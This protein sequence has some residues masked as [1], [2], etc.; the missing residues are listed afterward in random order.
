MKKINYT[1]KGLNVHLISVLAILVAIASP[2]FDTSVSNHSFVKT[3]V[4][5]IG[6]GILLL[7]TF[8]IRPN[9]THTDFHISWLKSSLL[10]LFILGTLSVF[11]SVNVD[12]TITKWLIWFTILCAFIVGYHLKLDN[13]VLIKFCWGLLIATFVITGI[14]LLQYWFDPFSL[15]QAAVPSSTFGNKNMATQPVVMMWPLALF[16]LFSKHIK[17]QQVWIVLTLTSLAMVFIVFTG[18]RSS[19]LAV[20]GQIIII[21]G[22]LLIK[23]K[24][25]STWI[26]WDKN[27]TY[28]SLFALLLLLLLTNLNNITV[29]TETAADTLASIGK[30]AIQYGGGRNVRLNIWPIA[31]DMIKANPV[32]GSGLGT[33]FHNEVQGGFGTYNVINYQRVHNDFLELGVEVGLAGMALLLVISAAVIVALFKIINHDNKINACFY[34]LILIALSGSFVQM[35]FSFPYQLAMP[36]L[37]FGLYTGFIGKQSEAFIKPLKIFTLKTSNAY[38]ATI[39][40]FYSLLILASS[41]LYIQWINTYSGINSLHKKQ[42]LHL[43]NEVI[44]PIYHLEIQNIFNL[45]GKVHLQ[46]NNLDTSIIVE[47]QLLKYWPNANISLHRYA[48]ALMRKKRYQQALKVIQHL[49]KVSVRGMFLGHLDELQLYQESKQ[50]EKVSE[51]FAAM[52]SID[53]KRLAYN[54]SMYEFLLKYSLYTPILSKYKDE[55]YQ[56]NIKHYGYTCHIEKT[57]I[58]YY[59]KRGNKEKAAPYME[60]VRNELSHNCEKY[61]TLK[62]KARGLQI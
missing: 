14:G 12:F 10:A 49:K 18:T 16:L 47:Q 61:I 19:W 28:A 24:T 32:F 37:L 31:I 2:W 13:E 4:T 52:L 25:F 60:N 53:E 5:G 58:D 42:K 26:N 34:F 8:W 43:I 45:L 39:I 51:V 21:G 54:D 56:K 36:A 27:K 22:F 30:Q 29:S 15:T 6:I 3:Y 20:I 46:A 48:Q 11:W 7:T 41:V 23:R 40:G 38:R 44:P 17:S 35:Q 50:S 9:K 55:I 33:W 57:M 62:L 1:H 59:V